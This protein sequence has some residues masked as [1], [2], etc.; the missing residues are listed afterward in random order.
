MPHGGVADCAAK[1]HCY[2]LESFPP[3]YCRCFYYEGKLVPQPKGEKNPNN[4]NPDIHTG[5]EDNPDAE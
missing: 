2:C 5:D 4:T 3:K 1:R